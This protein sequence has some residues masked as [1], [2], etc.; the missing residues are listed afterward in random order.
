MFSQD[1]PP[2]PKKGTCCSVPGCSLRSGTNL[3]SA[4]RAHRFPADPERRASWLQA[5]KRDNW[6]PN[7]NSRICSAHFIQGG[8][9]D[10]PGH[11]DYCP[12]LF[13]FRKPRTSQQLQRYNRQQAR[14]SKRA[15]AEAKDAS[16]DHAPTE[17]EDSEGVEHCE[18][19]SK[20]DMSVGTMLTI[21]DIERLEAENGKLR[22]ALAETQ[23]RLEET[24]KLLTEYKATNQNLIA[25]FNG[26]SATQ[27][28]LH[29]DTRV[30]FYTGIVS[31]QMFHT[32][33]SFILSFWQP[34][35]TSLQP[36][37]Q[38]VLV[39]MKLR[40]GLLNDDLA[41]RFRVSAKT[42]GA[43]FHAWLD[44]LSCN[45][46]KLIV[47]PSQRAVRRNRPCAFRDPVFRNVIG[48]LDC[49]EIFI[50][51]PSYMLARS[52]TY[53]RYKH[54][55]TVKVLI[56]VSPSGAV[57]FI[58]RAWGGRVSDKELTLKSGLLNI[59]REGDVYLV[60]RGFRC[61]EMFAAKG[62]TLL[63]PAFTKGKK[64]LSGAEVTLSRKLS[65]AR[66]HVERAIRRLK[67]FR[68]F[69]TVL[70]ISFVKKS[71]D[72]AM[73]TIDKALIVCAA[74]TNL[75]LPLLKK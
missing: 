47:W 74:L 50:Q 54:H 10:D 69:Q 61:Q 42:V 62:A 55:N 26:N 63:I 43:V 75:Q 56:T 59:V 24:D 4:V 36:Q 58:S 6:R 33:L 45:L 16:V 20:C 64:Q 8:P 30:K 44:I 31:V 73:C 7:N 17:S 70:P 11:P 60:D 72:V 12:S 15:G 46:A 5:M 49:T 41:C 40:L 27:A 51:K 39:L 67:V 28:A 1:V 3:L 34:E 38:L 57:T 53:S 13:P 52:Q 22:S 14:C 29:S 25:G 71:D 23:N 18:S 48:V 37:E 35:L 32:L 65:R 21:K 2:L 9:S 19:S 66:I 68:I